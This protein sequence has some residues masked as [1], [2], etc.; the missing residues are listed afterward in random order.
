MGTIMEKPPIGVIP[1]YLWDERRLKD[2]FDAMTRFSE[3]GVAI[4]PEW[5]IEYFE[6][7]RR[8]RDRH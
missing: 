7:E 4:P 1:Q 6:I 3:A 5:P 2:L 8:L